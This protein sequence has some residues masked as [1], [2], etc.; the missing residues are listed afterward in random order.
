LA[1]FEW[2]PVVISEIVTIVQPIRA[3]AICGISESKG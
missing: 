1:R 3:P 2:S